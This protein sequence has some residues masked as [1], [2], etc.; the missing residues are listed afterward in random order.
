MLPIVRSVKLYCSILN[1]FDK[2]GQIPEGMSATSALRHEAFN[3][4][5]TQIKDY[6]L[7][8]ANKFD[9]YNAF[10]PPY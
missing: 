8:E 10:S 7:D 5:H 6:V 2:A 9:N 1:Y 4:L 3:K